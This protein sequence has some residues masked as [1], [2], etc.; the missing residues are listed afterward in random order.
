MPLGRRSPSFLS[1]G[2]F[3]IFRK[4]CMPLCSCVSVCVCYCYRHSLGW[5]GLSLSKYYESDVKNGYHYWVLLLNFCRDTIDA[6][7]QSAALTLLRLLRASPDVIPMGEWTSRIIHLLNDQHMVGLPFSEVHRQFLSL[8]HTH[9]S[10]NSHFVL[11]MNYYCTLLFL[12]DKWKVFSIVKYT[13]ECIELC[14][15]RELWP[16]LPA[17]L[18]LLSRK[19]QRNTKAVYL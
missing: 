10:L 3:F 18:R 17:W 15:F 1:Q 14:L 5:L 8:P 6:V 12:H 13:S 19:T 16:Q 7:K 2:K 4:G 9:F 11:L